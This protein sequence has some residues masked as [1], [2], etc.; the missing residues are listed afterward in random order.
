M[1]YG[2]NV[3][4]CQCVSFAQTGICELEEVKLQISSRITAKL[5]TWIAYHSDSKQNTDKKTFTESLCFYVHL[6]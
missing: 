6:G 5:I 3:N 4:A 2:Y 1:I